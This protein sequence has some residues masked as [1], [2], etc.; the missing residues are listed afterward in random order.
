MD[1]FEK[2]LDEFYKNFGL[3]KPMVLSTSY[4]DYVTSRMMSVVVIDSCFYFQ[5]DNKF[6][7]YMQIRNNPRV[8]LCID[9]V[10]V[11]GH[12]IELGHPLKNKAFC[13]EYSKL[14]PNAYNRYSN[15]KNEV[16]F[17]VI[18]DWIQRW[19]YE[20]DVPYIEIYDCEEKRY[21]KI[22]YHG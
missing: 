9:N 2:K 19:I 3:G 6:R 1:T 8:S 18:P 12:C 17:K 13:D 5:T 21:E 22:L 11:E 14:F 20:Q 10:Q 15:L 4:Q 7:K 16:L